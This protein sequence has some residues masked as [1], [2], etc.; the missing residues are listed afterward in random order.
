MQS[1]STHNTPRRRLQELPSIPPL[2]LPT[3]DKK[4]VLY[5]KRDYTGNMFRDTDTPGHTL[6]LEC[7]IT[8]GYTG[9]WGFIPTHV[10]CRQI[11]ASRVCASHSCA[12]HKTG[13]TPPPSLSLKQGQRKEENWFTGGGNAAFLCCAKTSEAEFRKHVKVWWYLLYVC[14]HVYVCVL[15][16]FRAEGWPEPREETPWTCSHWTPKAGWRV[17][18]YLCVCLCVFV[19][20]RDRWRSL[21][22][23]ECLIDIF[24]FFFFTLELLV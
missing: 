12:K 11:W 16:N 9:R 1:S 17:C 2:S 6:F 18:V 20:G 4:E 24:F 7:C 23:G 10:Q 21:K 3:P 15:K 14:A 5:I 8:N 13:A 22:L 19:C